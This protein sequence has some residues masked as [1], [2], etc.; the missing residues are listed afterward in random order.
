MDLF[1]V[2]TGHAKKYLSDTAASVFPS[3]DA[4]A[5][6]DAFDTPLQDESI[7]PLQVIELLSSSGAD[8]TVRSSAGRYFGFVTGGSVPAALV[9]KL[10]LTVWDQNAALAIQSPVAAKLEMVAAGWLIDL[11]G[12]HDDTGVGFVTGATMANFTALVSARQHLLT[13]F[14]WN[15]AAD[16][17]F[18]APPITVIV[19]G[20]VHVS[21]LKALNLAGFGRERVV[22]VPVDGQGRMDVSRLPRIDGPTIVCAQAGNVNTGAFDDLKILTGLATISTWVHVDAAFGLWAAVSPRLAHLV[23]GIEA[24]D[25]IAT[26]AHKWLNVPYDCGLVFVRN[27]I[28]LINAMTSGAAYLPTG[29]VREPF[30]FVPEL[31][32]EARGIPVWA[33]LRSLGRNGIR[34]IVERNCELATRFGDAMV[35]KGYNVL[36]DV[37]LNQV[38]VSFGSD[39]RTTAVIRALERDGTAWYG[40]TT[41]QGRVAMR[42]S[43]SS[44]ATTETDVDRAIEAIDRVASG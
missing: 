38:L 43:I 6:L 5:A 16:G 36:N 21:L 1:D 4:I 24:A 7:D 10:I 2:F 40:G 44:W 26:D 32:R 28:R 12:L 37:V 35:A 13:Q 42:I 11:L 17:L 3:P 19:G 39:E 29:D 14:G 22:R 33:A 25:S 20:E 8:G 23:K 41:W 9:A 27:R 15:A 31:S 30:Q 18:G 34:E